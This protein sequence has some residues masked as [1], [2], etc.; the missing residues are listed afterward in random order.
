MLLIVCVRVKAANH[1][2]TYDVCSMAA[3]YTYT[4]RNFK[5]STAFARDKSKVASRVLPLE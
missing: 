4:Q 1:A 5:V 3:V 2:N